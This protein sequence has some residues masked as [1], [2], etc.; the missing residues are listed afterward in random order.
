ME[1]ALENV[2]SDQEVMLTP[3][4]LRAARVLIGWSGAQLAKE[5]GVP[6]R[7]IENFE[8]EKTTPLLTTAAKLRRTLEKN[9]VVFIDPD[10]ELGPGVRLREGALK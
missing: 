10:K 6:L 7:T 2:P 1:L 5:S 9:G 3:R 8:T 4:Q